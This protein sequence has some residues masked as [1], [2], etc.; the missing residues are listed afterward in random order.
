[1]QNQISG[2]GFTISHGCISNVLK[3]P[4]KI[5]NPASQTT[6]DFL[7]TT[8]HKPCL[9]SLSGMGGVLR[10]AQASRGIRS[11]RLCRRL[12]RYSN[13]ARRRCAHFGSNERQLPRKALFRFPGT[14]LARRNPG[15][16]S[17][18]H[19]A[20]ATA[21]KRRRPLGF[22]AADAARPARPSRIRESP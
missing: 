7:I 14:V 3:T 10:A 9:R 13:S 4:I 11:G 6:K 5:Q 12:K 2:R 1:V 8:Q 22:R 20:L 21:S 16:S 19:P 18:A 15:L 17:A